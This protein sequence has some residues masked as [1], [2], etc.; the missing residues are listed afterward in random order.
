MQL[1]PIARGSMLG[2]A[3]AVLFGITTPLITHFGRGVGPFATATLLYGGAALGAGLPLRSS[4]PSL[5]RAQLGRL[6][7][8]ALF[9]AALA[10]ASLAWGLQH[11]GALSASLLLN[12]EAVFTVFLARAIHREPI[13]PAALAREVAGDNAEVSV[14][15]TG[16]P[17]KWSLDPARIREVLVNLVDNALAAGPPVVVRVA[18]RDRSCL[19][20]VEDRGPGVPESER[21]NIFSAFVTTKTHGTGLGLAVVRRV[22]ELHG[23]TV[24]VDVGRGSAEAPGAIFRV[25]IPEA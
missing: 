22:V 9:G 20:E 14:D 6:A 18:R 13:D 19:F 7:A 15:A 12:L 21:E 11:T 25:E 16:A 4:A 8:V 5:G 3:A 2:V 10:P 23:G 17:S 24:T 1:A